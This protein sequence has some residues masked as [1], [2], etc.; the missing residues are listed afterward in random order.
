MLI[1]S[2]FSI[3]METIKLILN[4]SEIT[5]GTRGASLGPDA[6]KA[7]ARQRQSRFF[8][9]FEIVDVKDCNELLDQSVKHPFAKRID[10]LVTV[11]ERVATKVETVFKSK[12]F[13]VVIAADHGS[14]GGT[15][16]GIAKTFPNARL[17]IIWIDAHADLHTPYTTPS[18]NLHGMPLATALGIDNK[19]CQINEVDEETT[20]KWEQLKSTG[21]DRAKLLPE[22]LVFIA[23]R[24]TEPEEDH[25]LNEF[26]LTN[27]TVDQLREMGV[28]QVVKSVLGKL[29]NCDLIYVSFDVDSMDPELTSHGTGTPVKHG[30]SPEEAAGLLEGFSAV[31][32]TCCVEFVEV[33]PCLDEKKNK[34]AEVAFELLERTVAVI[35]NR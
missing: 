16:A 24:D 30:L 20:S 33:N 22:D 26:G 18:G 6:I 19:A 21:I 2:H 8:D 17:G 14:A 31:E 12:G 7:A 10:G 29:K 35:A 4:R 1:L 34:M 15:I 9:H 32:K 28:E 13:P 3:P 23:V 11:F 27:I 5:A 25:L